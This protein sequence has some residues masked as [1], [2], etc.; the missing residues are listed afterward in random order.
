MPNPPNHPAASDQ[1]FPTLAYDEVGPADR[2][3]LVWLDDR[4]GAAPGAF[5]KLYGVTSKNGEHVTN[6]YPA[7]LALS[8]YY[9]SNPTQF[10]ELGASNIGV[11]VDRTV[12]AQGWATM[13]SLTSENVIS[14]FQP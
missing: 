5:G 2:L 3:G 14:W 6:L 1:L 10:G 13:A 11:G 12:Q 4:D 9:P 7:A 8:T